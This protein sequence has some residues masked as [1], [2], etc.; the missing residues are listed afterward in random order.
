MGKSRVFKGIRWWKTWWKNKMGPRLDFIEFPEHALIRSQVDDPQRLHMFIHDTPGGGRVFAGHGLEKITVAVSANAFH[1]W[2]L[3]GVR[4]RR[5]RIIRH[6]VPD[7][8]E[9]RQEDI[10]GLR[11]FLLL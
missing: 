7:V 2:S 6:L 3:H 9:G 4:D 10:T 5:R 8:V 11:A 1:G